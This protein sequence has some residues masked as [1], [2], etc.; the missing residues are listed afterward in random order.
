MG[1]KFVLSWKVDMAMGQNPATPV[2]TQK[3]FKIDYNR[4]VTIPKRDTHSVLTHSHIS[5]LGSLAVGPNACHHWV[6]LSFIGVIL[7]HEAK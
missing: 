7:R 3:A 2:N 4:V 1:T 5:K 6:D